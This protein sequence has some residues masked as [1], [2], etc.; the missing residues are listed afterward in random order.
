[1][2]GIA[3]TVNNADISDCRTF[4]D[5][6]HFQVILC[7]WMFESLSRIDLVIL[8]RFAL[9]FWGN[10]IT[11]NKNR[12]RWPSKIQIVRISREF[13][14]DRANRPTVWDFVPWWF[15]DFDVNIIIITAKDHIDVVVVFQGSCICIALRR[16]YA[17]GNATFN[18][19][20]DHQLICIHL[21]KRS[22]Q[23]I[24]YIKSI[25]L[26]VIWP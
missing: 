12:E 1:M 13:P 9:E 8:C 4:K 18:D 7:C 3:F 16:I 11:S 5:V 2:L 10:K 23:N 14:H 24:P 17:K 25:Y 21:R 19:I 6:A 26:N 22:M 20:T 15:F